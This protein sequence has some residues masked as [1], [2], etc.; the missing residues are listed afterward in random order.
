MI[1]PHQRQVQAVWL[2]TDG[3]EPALKYLN[4]GLPKEAQEHLEGMLQ[5]AKSLPAPFY[6]DLGLIYEVNGQLDDAEAMYKKAAALD[7]NEMYLRAISSVRQ[8]K[9][10][11]KK[12]VE[13]QRARQE[14]R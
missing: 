3:T 9:E 11:H 4:A 8:A 12:L 7:L 2:P 5:R 13:Q 14:S 1:S 6:Y 10:D